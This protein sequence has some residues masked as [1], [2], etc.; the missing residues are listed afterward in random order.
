MVRLV[1]QGPLLYALALLTIGL[2][3]AVAQFGGAVDLSAAVASLPPS[4][5]AIA[6]PIDVDWLVVPVDRKTGVYRSGPK[7]ITMANGLISRTWRV[8]PNGAC[9][10]FNNLI[11]GSSI[12][13]GVKPE[14]IV[15]L[16]G[17]KYSVGG[18]V[19][20]PQY[21]YLRP[22]WIDTLKAD[23]AAFQLTGF[24]VGRTKER[25]AWKRTPYS[26]DV[27]LA[28]AGRVADAAFHSRRPG[29]CLG[30][31]PSRSTTRCTTGFR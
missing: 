21:A 14:A 17:T 9:V 19:G 8:A 16:D 20:Q 15:Q 24:E 3:V 31:W 2:P 27:A 5:A 29:S 12:I 13:R 7:E 22:E 18:L 6:A 26:A 4:S 25:F 28:A 11:T 30:T 23:P 10:G 1:L